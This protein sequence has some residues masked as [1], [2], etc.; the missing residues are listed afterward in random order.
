MAKINLANTSVFIAT[1][2]HGAQ[3]SVVYTQALWRTVTEFS[4]QGVKSGLLMMDGASVEKSRNF[5]TARFMDSGMTHLLWVDADQGW[6]PMDVLRLV[7]QDKPYV[8][9]A[10]RKKTS[11]V[12]WNCN[13]I[14][15][16]EVN[17]NG[18][19]KVK[20]LGTGFCLMHR[21]VIEQMIAKHPE[22]RITEDELSDNLYRLFYDEV[23]DGRYWGEDLSFARRWR[24]LCGGEI[25]IDVSMT[26]S[27]FG[28][29]DFKGCFGDDLLDKQALHADQNQ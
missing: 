23:E 16:E 15:G 21:E 17:E 10:V 2:T 28:I 6:Q 4:R 26:V 24:K 3:N 8:G 18:L 5:L 27:H 22:Q 9:V 7:A 25:F 14:D 13:F 11:E 1:P 29:T 19:L 12:Q 20:E